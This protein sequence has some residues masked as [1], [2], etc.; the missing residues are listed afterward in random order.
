MTIEQQDETKVEPKGHVVEPAVMVPSE[1]RAAVEQSAVWE[2]ALKEFPSATVIEMA[3]QP[4]M[5]NEIVQLFVKLNVPSVFR[6]LRVDGGEVVKCIFGPYNIVPPLEFG[7]SVTANAYAIVLVKNT[8]KD[9]T[10]VSGRLLVEQEVTV[11]ASNG[12]PTVVAAHAARSGPPPTQKN[13]DIKP[14]MNEVVVL[15]K[16]GEA[17][18]LLRSLEGGHLQVTPGEAPPYI[19]AFQDALARA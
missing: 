12:P 19:R 8:G 6:G 14:G 2:G 15:M 17:E 11:A 13:A 18:R 9:T 3:S 7:Q 1:V 5:P 4:A 10:T 16:R